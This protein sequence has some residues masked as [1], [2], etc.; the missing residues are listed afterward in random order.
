MKESR[1]LIKRESFIN[2]FIDFLRKNEKLRQAI[3]KTYGPQAYSWEMAELERSRDPLCKINLFR[4]I[5]SLCPEIYIDNETEFED[6]IKLI[7]LAQDK[8]TQNQLLFL[9]TFFEPRFSVNFALDNL[10]GGSGAIDEINYSNRENLIEVLRKFSSEAIPFILKRAPLANP[11]LIQLLVPYFIHVGSGSFKTLFNR[12]KE[13]YETD[14]TKMIEPFVDTCLEPNL[15][16]VNSHPF[17]IRFF[18]VPG[19]DNYPDKAMYFLRKILSCPEIE[20]VL[21]HKQTLTNHIFKCFEKGNEKDVEVCLD[22]IERF[23]IRESSKYIKT[24]L[25]RFPHKKLHILSSFNSFKSESVMNYYMEDYENSSS[26]E[27]EVMIRY[28]IARPREDTM[29]FLEKKY[30]QGNKEDRKLILQN[31]W[32]SARPEGKE[33]VRHA[34]SSGDVE[35]ISSA[36]EKLHYLGTFFDEKEF[37]Q[38]ILKAHNLGIVINRGILNPLSHLLNEDLCTSVLNSMENHFDFIENDRL[39]FAGYFTNPQ[40]YPVI[41]TY[42]D[43]PETQPQAIIASLASRNKKAVD[44]ITGFYNEYNL[45]FQDFIIDNISKFQDYRFLEVIEAEAYKYYRK[46]DSFTPGDGFIVALSRKE[47]FDILQEL[48]ERNCQRSVQFMLEISRYGGKK[49]LPIL[50]DMEKE[51]KIMEV[52]RKRA[53]LHLAKYIAGNRENLEELLSYFNDEYLGS[54]LIYLLYDTAKRADTV[55]LP[56]LDSYETVDFEPFVESLFNEMNKYY[57]WDP[58]FDQILEIISRG[59]TDKHALKLNRH[60]V[61]SFVEIEMPILKAMERLAHPDNREVLQD[62]L[63][64]LNTISAQNIINLREIIFRISLL[65]HKLGDSDSYTRLRSFYRA[66]LFRYLKDPMRFVNIPLF[67]PNLKDILD[68]KDRTEI[69]LNYYGKFLANPGE[70]RNTEEA[71]LRMIEGIQDHRFIGLII[72][73]LRLCQADVDLIPA[74][75]RLKELTGRTYGIDY[76]KWNEYLEQNR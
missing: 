15:V 40:T 4:F 65:L 11:D 6:F 67:F 44:K 58:I 20:A 53:G 74:L 68:E 27:K 47:G 60:L 46:V 64:L 38:F 50:E 55:L 7:K 70:L 12:L 34:F 35:L 39:S 49:A 72:K 3:T 18:I 9:L 22:F 37:N 43:K 31:L 45:E 59:V 25:D 13:L 36:I 10:I 61:G 32:L 28:L 76:E 2:F 21:E 23:P 52:P 5:K 42:M 24:L 62:T 29:K 69:F 66:R 51:Q 1:A 73:N 56:Q 19:M 41:E 33:W 26:G 17:L 30:F 14:E 71:L 75:Q 57:P 54:Y 48:H 8:R 16:P 63:Q